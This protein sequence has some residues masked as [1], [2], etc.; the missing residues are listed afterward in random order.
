MF[1]EYPQQGQPQSP[2][3]ALFFLLINRNEE[4]GL[5][6]DRRVRDETREF[7]R[8]L[9]EVLAKQTKQQPGA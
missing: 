7:V 4:E 8:S 5:Q 1:P 2:R 9:P 3:L 6:H